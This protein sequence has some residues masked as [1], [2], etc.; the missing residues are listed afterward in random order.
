MLS[1]TSK[2][3]D[4]LKEAKRLYVTVTTFPEHATK[5]LA[6]ARTAQ[7]K[8]LLAFGLSGLLEQRVKAEVARRGAR[9]D[10]RFPG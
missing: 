8:L 1:V 7:L 3:G 9:N 5:L 2:R 4:S 10:R 6:N